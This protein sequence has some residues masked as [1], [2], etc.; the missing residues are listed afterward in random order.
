MPSLRSLPMFYIMQ[1]LTIKVKKKKDFKNHC[2]SKA[3]SIMSLDYHSEW[4]SDHSMANS[5]FSDA[6]LNP[7]E[8]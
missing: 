3:H 4:T 6:S 8:P 1:R 5:N 7:N 2:R